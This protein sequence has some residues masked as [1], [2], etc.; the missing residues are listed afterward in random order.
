MFGP[1]LN[2]GLEPRT[3]EP[4]RTCVAPARTAC[5]RSPLIPAD[6]QVA[7]GCSARKSRWIAASRSKAARGLLPERRDR[8]QAAQPQ[9][10]RPPRPR[11]P[12]TRR[13][14]GSA[15]GAALAS[16][17]VQ[18]DLEQHVDLVRARV[19]AA[20]RRADELG[21]V[22]RLDD[23]GVR[24]DGGRLVALETAD[25]VPGEVEVG[26]LGGLGLGLLVAVLPHV[27]DAEVGEQPHVAGGEELGDHHQADVVG[28][29][30]GVGARAGDPSPDG[31]EV[32]GELVAPRAH[33]VRHTTPASRPAASPSR[34]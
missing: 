15:P 33:D 19:R 25:E 18:A 16:G 14:A 27:G 5:S 2:C 6:S 24:R 3:A 9:H 32:G 21:A 1:Y 23:V 34:R 22:D 7:S 20:A 30:P 10:R 4:T 17:R 12:A 13:S 31:L 11:R 29:A 26:A 8:H 28:R